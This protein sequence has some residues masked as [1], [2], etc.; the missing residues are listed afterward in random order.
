[1]MPLN[2][3]KHQNLDIIKLKRLKTLLMFFTELGSAMINPFLQK[4]WS[5]WLISKPCLFLQTYTQIIGLSRCFIIYQTHSLYLKTQLA[6]RKHHFFT[7][8][9]HRGWHASSVWAAGIALSAS[10]I[11][12]PPVFSQ[13]HCFVLYD[14]GV[15]CLE[16]GHL[17]KFQE[18]CHSLKGH[19]TMF[20]YLSNLWA[21]SLQLS[22][23]ML[24]ERNHGALRLK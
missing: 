16:R 12:S 13:K 14:S 18:P 22:G 9:L 3:R 24:M 23:V 2:I 7:R 11:S 15:N 1:M 19:S 5:A 4:A 21:A 10:S 6:K 17:L 8:C 20:M